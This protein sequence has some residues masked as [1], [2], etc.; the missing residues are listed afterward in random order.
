MILYRSSPH[1]LSLNRKEQL[2]YCS[3][4]VC[5]SRCKKEKHR[6]PYMMWFQTYGR[7]SLLVIRLIHSTIPSPLAPYPTRT[8][9]N[10]K[11]FLTLKTKVNTPQNLEGN[12]Q[13][14]PLSWFDRYGENSRH[15]EQ[16]QLIKEQNIAAVIMLQPLHL[17]KNRSA[18]FAN[19]S[20]LGF[21][22]FD[23]PQNQWWWKSIVS[24]VRWGTCL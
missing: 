17:N 4:L 12:V 2:D 16:Q 15:Q 9:L 8:V 11:P 13:Q 3:S 24:P 1:S 19:L 5:C 7:I 21:N 22:S 23:T 6:L 18:R 14:G 20:V 10:I